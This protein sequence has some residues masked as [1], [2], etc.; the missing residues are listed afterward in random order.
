MR[1]LSSGLSSVLK[2]A[3][4]FLTCLNTDLKSWIIKGGTRFTIIIIHFLTLQTHCKFQIIIIIIIIGYRLSWRNNILYHF[5]KRKYEL[6]FFQIR[7]AKFDDL[8]FFSDEFWVSFEQRSKKSCGKAA[9]FHNLWLCLSIPC[10]LCNV[11]VRT[12][13]YQKR[14]RPG[15]KPTTLEWISNEKDYSKNLLQIPIAK[16]EP[17]P[18]L[19]E[20]HNK[21]PRAVNQ[22]WEPSFEKIIN[23][24]G[25]LQPWTLWI[26]FHK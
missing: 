16:C 12:D 9:W 6:R 22:K 25:L 26:M 19:W 7:K 20:I 14:A 8:R 13:R 2:C 5:A 10:D 23:L 17:F 11:C 21:A 24:D 3:F 18:L 4:E 15:F 1:R